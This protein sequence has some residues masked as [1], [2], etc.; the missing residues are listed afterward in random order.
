MFSLN[1]DTYVYTHKFRFL[2]FKWNPFCKFRW[3]GLH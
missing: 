1:I 3:D 2:H